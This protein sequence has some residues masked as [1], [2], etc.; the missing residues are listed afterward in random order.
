MWTNDN[1]PLPGCIDVIIYTSVVTYVGAN[2]YS[3]ARIAQLFLVNH[4][5]TRI[6]HQCLRDTD[7]FRC[8]IVFQQSGNNA[9]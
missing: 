4:F 1:S 9:W 3:L 8:L 5:K 6:R 2:Y 7:T